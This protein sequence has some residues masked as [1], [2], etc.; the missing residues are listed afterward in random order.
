MVLTKSQ[1]KRLGVCPKCFEKKVLTNHHILPVRHYGRNNWKISLCRSCH[2]DIE[3]ILNR[4]ES[5]RGGRL[6]HNEYL[7]IIREFIQTPWYY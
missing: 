1:K 5:D 4:L 2:N 3:V 6:K 7:S